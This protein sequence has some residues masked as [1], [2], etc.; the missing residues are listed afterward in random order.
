MVALA[1]AAGALV[2]WT[3]E[4]A[5]AMQVGSKLADPYLRGSLLIIAGLAALSTLRRAPA[6]ARGAPCVPS[7]VLQGINHGRSRFGSYVVMICLQLVGGAMDMAWMAVIAAWMLAA[8]MLP[9]TK[10]FSTLAGFSL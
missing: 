4:S 5:G 6:Q 9:R 8:A 2:E 3:L 10:Q 7:P 1:G